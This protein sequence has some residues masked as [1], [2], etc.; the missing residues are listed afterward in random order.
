MERIG[1]IHIYCGDGKGKT[2]A[3]TGLAVRMAG[4]QGKVLFTQFFK[5]GGSSEIKAMQQIDGITTMHADTVCK[6]YVNMNEDQVVDAKESMQRLLEAIIEE[7]PKYDLLVLDEII[8]AYTYEMFDRNTLLEFLKCRPKTLEIVMTGRDPASELV[9]LADYVSEI[10]KI[11][12]P[13]DRGIDA[14]RGIEF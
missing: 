14:R 3:A 2:T 9:E 5:N 6:R 4:N 11:K 12:H 13:Y 1:L 10:K 8:S 7:A